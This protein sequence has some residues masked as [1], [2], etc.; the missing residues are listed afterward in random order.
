MGLQLPDCVENVVGKGQNALYEQFLLFPQ[1][2]KKL[3][4]VDASK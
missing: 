1:C 2:F 4:V 3:S